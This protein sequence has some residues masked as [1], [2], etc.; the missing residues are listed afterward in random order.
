MYQLTLLVGVKQ[1]KYEAVQ[2]ALPIVVV[3]N[4]GALFPTACLPYSM[5]GKIY[6][7]CLFYYHGYVYHCHAAD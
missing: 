6:F 7:L 2:S 1:M 4:F 5:L 3:K